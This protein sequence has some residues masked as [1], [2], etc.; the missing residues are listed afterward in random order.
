MRRDIFFSEYVWEEACGAQDWKWSGLEIS[1]QIELQLERG[2]NLFGSRQFDCSITENNASS[3]SPP[4][5]NNSLNARL[6]WHIGTFV[7]LNHLGDRIHRR[8]VSGVCEDELTRDSK[9]QHQ[10]P[11]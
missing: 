9:L 3:L 11:Q 7:P 5:L 2:R 6:G 8:P 4:R 10:T 1:G